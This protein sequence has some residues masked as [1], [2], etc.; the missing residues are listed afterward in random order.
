MLGLYLQK[1]HNLRLLPPSLFNLLIL[2]FWMSS[3]LGVWQP[4][5]IPLQSKCPWIQDSILLHKCIIFR[6]TYVIVEPRQYLKTAPRGMR[7]CS[8]IPPQGSAMGSSLTQGHPHTRHACWADVC[9]V[10]HSSQA[11]HRVL[12]TSQRNWLLS[13][14]GT[15]EKLG[16]LLH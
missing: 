11:G 7:G 14:E 15:W 9:M 8:A 16:Q 1:S 3:S 12:P 10:Q 13:T 6:R 5:E 2:S 4:P